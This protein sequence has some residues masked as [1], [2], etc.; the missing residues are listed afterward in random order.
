MNHPDV[1]RAIVEDVI[2]N[3]DE[4]GVCRWPSIAATGFRVEIWRGFEWGFLGAGRVQVP[5]AGDG[6]VT[7]RVSVD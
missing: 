6:T 3:T 2:H 4:H 1:P 5:A 7:I